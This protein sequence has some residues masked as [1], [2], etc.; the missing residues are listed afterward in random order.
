MRPYGRSAAPVLFAVAAEIEGATLREILDRRD[1]PGSSLVE[2][3]GVGTASV[4]RLQQV[5]ERRSPRLVVTP[6]LAGSLDP[7]LRPGDL[8]VIEGWVAQPPA[9]TPVRSAA[10]LV[11][12]GEEIARGAGLTPHRGQAITVDAP[13]HDRERRHRLH[14]GTGARVV[15]M[16]GSHWAAA[17]HAAGASFLSLRVISDDAATPLPLPR[18]LLLQRNGRIRWQRWLRAVAEGGTTVSAEA[19]IRRL[20]RARREWLLAMHTLDALA[21]TLATASLD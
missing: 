7:T 3:I 15:E 19:E 4:A 17:V 9:G 10:E 2:T 8:V 16:E 20:F 21:G 12:R 14:R 5:L 13:L 18:H 1:P 11:A 6:G